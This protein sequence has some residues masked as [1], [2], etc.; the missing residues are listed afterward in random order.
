MR[1][2]AEVSNTRC[3]TRRPVHEMGQRYI[4]IDVDE[5]IRET[6]A[7]FL[8]LIDGREVW[9]PKSVMENEAAVMIGECEVAVDIAAW[10]V[11]KD[12]LE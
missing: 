3:G 1:W 10:F 5:V 4:A 6:A 2:V 8:F 12:G 7:A 11:K 9:V